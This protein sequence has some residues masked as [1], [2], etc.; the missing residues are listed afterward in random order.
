MKSISF[1]SERV[2]LVQARFLVSFCHILLAYQAY[3]SNNSKNNCSCLWAKPY[4][5]AFTYAEGAHVTTTTFPV[6]LSTSSFLFFFSMPFLFILSFNAF[7]L[8]LVVFEIGLSTVAGLITSQS[9]KRELVKYIISN[10][11]ADLLALLQWLPDFG[12]L[13]AVS[14]HYLCNGLGG[15][16]VTFQPKV[17][18]QSEIACLYWVSLLLEADEP[19][20]S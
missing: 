7:H 8:R 5:T 15:R 17:V 1:P 2:F 10:S 18:G 9:Y 6:L 13:L 20:V 3:S 11:L 16:L 12:V 19:D 14:R 4:T